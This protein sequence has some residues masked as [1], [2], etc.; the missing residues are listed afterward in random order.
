MKPK[1][2]K[3]WIAIALLSGVLVLVFL[4]FFLQPVPSYAG[5]DANFWFDNYGRYPSPTRTG[6]SPVDSVN[7]FRSMGASAAPFLVSKLERA[8]SWERWYATRW[9][10]APRWVQKTLPAPVGLADRRE[11][12][13]TLLAQL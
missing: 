12:A 7:A 4:Y 6:S 9:A 13:L 3:W 8:D 2:N 5:K 11:W 1:R 10:G